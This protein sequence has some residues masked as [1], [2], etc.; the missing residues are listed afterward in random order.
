MEFPLWQGG[1]ALI[2]EFP[3]KE[4]GSMLVF[5]LCWIGRK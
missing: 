1:T 5:A 4:T 2:Y 3:N